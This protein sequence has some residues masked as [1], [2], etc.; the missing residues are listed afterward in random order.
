MIY[1]GGDGWPAEYR[2]EIFMNN[3]HGHRVNMDRPGAQ[4][5]GLRREHGPDFLHDQRSW[6]QMLNFRYGPDG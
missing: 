2:D 4:R 1:L 5:L 3:I 6:S